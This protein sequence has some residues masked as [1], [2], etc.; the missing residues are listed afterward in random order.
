MSSTWMD[1]RQQTAQAINPRTST[2][3]RR[4]PSLLR[5]AGGVSHQPSPLYP[6]KAVVSTMMIRFALLLA[7]I[8]ALA[9]VRHVAASHSDSP[10]PHRL[11]KAV[12]CLTVAPLLTFTRVLP[13]GRPLP[14]VWRLRLCSRAERTPRRKRS[15]VI[16]RTCVNS[17]RAAARVLAA[18]SS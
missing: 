5:A 8:F 6:L 7:L 18:E 14:L 15:S 11:R 1:G 17:R 2:D 16:A 9:E 12:P 3:S 13:L 4:N 10:S